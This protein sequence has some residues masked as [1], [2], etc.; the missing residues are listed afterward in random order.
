MPVT[1]ETELALARVA[2]LFGRT[3]GSLEIAVR[4]V[5]TVALRVTRHRLALLGRD[6]V[7]CFRLR[8]RDLVVVLGAGL[9]GL[10]SLVGGVVGV[11]VR[12][13]IRVMAARVYS[14]A[15]LGSIVKHSNQRGMA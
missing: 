11:V 2:T 4:A 7:S 6:L 10:L 9:A 1:P 5:L 3:L 12:L 13:C 15:P 14:R 8:H